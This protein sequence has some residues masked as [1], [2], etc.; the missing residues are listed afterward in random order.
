MKKPADGATIVRRCS[1]SLTRSLLGKQGADERRDC[2]D[3]QAGQSRQQNQR[4]AVLL[5]HFQLP[6][7]PKGLSDQISGSLPRF[8]GPRGS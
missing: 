8:S 2:A 1:R 6:I 5:V 4:A 7:L 3:D